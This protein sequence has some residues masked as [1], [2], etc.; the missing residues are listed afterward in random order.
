MR[1]TLGV[2][3]TLLGLLAALGCS[4]SSDDKGDAGTGTAGSGTAGSGAAGTSSAGTGAAGTGSAGTG[5]AAV[6]TCEITDTPPTSCGGETCP[7]VPGFLA[8]ACQVVCCTEDDACGTRNASAE[9][10]GS[11][12]AD[13]N[14]SAELDPTCPSREI[15]FMGSMQTLEGCRLDDQRC[16]LSVL[17]AFCLDPCDIPGESCDEDAGT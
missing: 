7:A 12:L 10:V 2:V 13:C 14:A 17:G 15:M 16:G 6:L 8:D 1:N 5:D 9:A 11:P 3:V 4:S